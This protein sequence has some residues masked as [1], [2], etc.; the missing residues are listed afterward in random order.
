MMRSADLSRASSR[1][2][3]VKSL[4]RKIVLTVFFAEGSIKRPTLSQDSA[5]DV[6]ARIS[7]CFTTFFKSIV[8]SGELELKFL[9]NVETIL[10]DFKIQDI[11]IQLC[12][13]GLSMSMTRSSETRVI[14][15]IGNFL[16]KLLIIF[17]NKA[18]CYRQRIDIFI[19][20]NINKKIKTEQHYLGLDF[21]SRD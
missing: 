16:S 11:Q 1:T 12:D 10:E 4:V 14:L 18:R 13:R 5:R 8:C 6:G 7:N 19:K 21:S 15:V 2:G 20:Y 17:M 9:W 3:S